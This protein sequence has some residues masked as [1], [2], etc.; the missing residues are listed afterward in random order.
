MKEKCPFCR[1]FISNHER[2]VLVAAVRAHDECFKEH[3]IRHK[4]VHFR[5]PYKKGY[6]DEEG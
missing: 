1:Q 6:K 5:Q 4:P 2:T 3:L